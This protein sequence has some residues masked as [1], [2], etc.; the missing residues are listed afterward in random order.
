MNYALTQ[1][2]VFMLAAA[3]IHVV[4]Q[5][6]A[7]YSYFHKFCDDER[8]GSLVVLDESHVLNYFWNLTI[9]YMHMLQDIFDGEEFEG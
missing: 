5:R 7:L 4:E 9:L 2:K 1:R 8:S 3:R 6:L